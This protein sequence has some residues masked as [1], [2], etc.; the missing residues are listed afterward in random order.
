MSYFL[1]TMLINLLHLRVNITVFLA[2]KCLLSMCGKISSYRRYI[3]FL[4][5]NVSMDRDQY[6]MTRPV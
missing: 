5:R 6:T 3:L 2:V 1:A 4:V